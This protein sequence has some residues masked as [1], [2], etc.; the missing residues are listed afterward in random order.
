[1][2]VLYHWWFVYI[3]ICFKSNKIYHLGY[4]NM[5]WMKT[6]YYSNSILHKAFVC[7]FISVYWL[8]LIFQKARIC[9]N[10]NIL[11]FTKGS[12]LLIQYVTVTGIIDW[13]SM[14]HAITNLYDSIYRFVVMKGSKLFPVGHRRNLTRTQKGPIY[15]IV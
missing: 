5:F 12:F 8:E 3:T 1:M 10:Y 11:R 2:Y 14:A 7:I 15:S 6:I 13:I 9:C 4:N